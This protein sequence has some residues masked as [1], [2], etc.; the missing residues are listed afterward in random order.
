MSFRINTNIASMNAH[1]IGTAN[2]RG[3]SNSLTKLSSGLRINKS[4]DD[5]AGQAIAD[6]L[7]KQS[8]AISSAIKN[9]NEA[10]GI[11][12]IADSAMDEQIKIL[13]T[14]KVKA[15]QAAQDGQTSDTRK[16][17][18]SDIAKLLQTLDQIATTTTF[19]GQTL[20]DGSF[21]NKK[22]QVGA[23]ANQDINFSINSTHSS[24][25]GDV[26]FETTTI[27]SGTSG[28]TFSA[29]DGQKDLT[30]ESV[31]V[32]SLKSG[33][34]IAQI[35]NTINKNSI[36]LG[37]IRASWTNL[38][39]GSNAIVAT[40]V[41]DLK[42][43]NVVIGNIDS[44]AENDSNGKLVN[45]I[46]SATND[47]GVEAFVD[48]EGKINLRSIDGRGIVI[49]AT[50]GLNDLG[51][52]AGGESNFGR[53][54][55]RRDS[56]KDIVYSDS[57]GVLTTNT[58]SQGVMNLAD[59]KGRIDKD[60]ASAIGVFENANRANDVTS[61]SIGVGVTTLVGAMAIMD[62]ADSA[63][64]Q[65][66]KIRSQIGSN[67]TS[68]TSTINNISVTKINLDASQSQIRDADFASESST[69]QRQ[70]IL[71]QSGSYA[72]AQANSLPQN[73]TK[74]LQ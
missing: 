12:Q 62:V 64:K 8:S 33:T 49:S 43:N 30:I 27:V 29:V 67:Q 41:N 69:F 11:I 2:N 65:L 46:N 55:L 28:L 52:N 4:A 7:Q 14:I 57:G 35:A 45:T 20:L 47:T 71:S 17:I 21:V 23:F 48:N 66:D 61:N 6:S 13:D 44:V 31:D 74:L 5:E 37:G 68:F 59:L 56:A 72:L 51:L 1:Q 25:V 32:G 70:S 53:L 50:A 38:T 26:R 42:I 54:T 58:A 63:L 40:S 60:I 73:V 3:L 24:K 19:N 34:G 22:F 10:V 15:T 36:A 18:Q 39:T 9:A 16:A